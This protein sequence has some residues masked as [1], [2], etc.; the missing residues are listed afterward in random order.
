MK[1]FIDTANLDH[2]REAA[3][4]GVIDGCTTNPSLIAK[5]GRDF[6]DAIAEICTIVDGPV[7][8]ET[9]AD[10]AEE[11]IAQG[12]RLAKIHPNVVIKVPLTEAGITCCSALASARALATSWAWLSGVMMK[13]QLLHLSA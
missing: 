2:I 11:M 13:A 6:V 4:W 9:V 1:F 5:E 10:S 8:A 12:L 7:S 3:S